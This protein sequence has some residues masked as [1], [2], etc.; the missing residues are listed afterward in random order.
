MDSTTKQ[1]KVTGTGWIG[2]TRPGTAEM[3]KQVS[4]ASLSSSYEKTV[5]EMDSMPRPQG[6]TGR[7]Q[8]K[9]QTTMDSTTKKKTTGTGDFGSP[10]PGVEGIT[11]V[12]STS[13]SGNRREEQVSDQACSSLHATGSLEEA[14]ERCKMNI[15]I[16]DA[17]S[18]DEMSTVRRAN[19]SKKRRR[20][21]SSTTPSESD[22]NV[23]T[24]NER[25]SRLQ[26]QKTQNSSSFKRK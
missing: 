9:S 14:M 8:P 26:K 25:E 5:S 22:T 10:R 7:K 18:G 20:A 17:S 2:T 24:G 23:G 4:A 1:G 21:I 11:R 16:S 19:S 12:P 3:F 15:V 6:T 13:S